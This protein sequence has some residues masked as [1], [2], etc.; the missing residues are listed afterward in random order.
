MNGRDQPPQRSDPL[1]RLIRQ[2]GFFRNLDRFDLA[3]LIGALEKV[4]FPS[5][6]FVFSE[7][8]DADALYLLESGRVSVTVTAANDDRILTEL[9]APSHFG[10]LGLLL[11]RRTGS[12]RAVTD[13]QVWKLPRQ[14][15]EEFVRE[16]P[17]MG[18]AVAA[19]LAELIDQRSREHAGAPAPSHASPLPV[20][21]PSRRRPPT[22]RLVGAAI[23][24]AVPLALWPIGPPRG[25]GTQ[26]WH[27]ALIICG[28]ALAWLSEPVPDFVVAL[29]MPTAWGIA[30]LVPLSVA[31]GGF[32]SSAWLVALGALGLGAAMAR[33]GLLFRIALRLMR[34]FPATYVGQL[35]A[36]LS[37][38]VLVT[39]L[40]PLA[41]ARVAT[42]APLAQELSQALGCPDRSRGSA[43]LSFAGIIGYGAFSSIF[44]TGLAMNFFVLDLVPPYDRAR[45]GWLS[46]LVGA[47]LAGV[48]ILIGATLA[49]LVLFRPETVPKS[50]PDLIRRQQR[51]LG[52]LSHAEIATITAITILIVGLILQPFFRT[53]PA[54]LAIASLIVILGG[55]ALDRGSFRASIDWGFLVLFGV[56]LGAGGVLHSVGVDRWLADALLPPIRSVGNPG[57]ILV[58]LGACV[59]ACRLVLPWIPATLLLSL[60]LVPAAPQL[61]LSPWL[62][63]FVILVT[64]NTWLH[65]NQSDFCRL[66]REATRGLMFT[67]RHGTLMGIAVTAVTLVAIA[68][69]LPYW[70]MI[71]LLA[72]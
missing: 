67:A 33:S 39:P 63:G 64:A 49:L 42:V 1:E 14:R 32:A 69:S 47:A 7:G 25:L 13:V 38:G 35:L 11:S 30:G 51:I 12:A 72:R 71:G 9:E 53:D 4:T 15:F 40:V 65:P 52:Q 46:W 10:E 57:T 2:V 20:L 36:L 31:F 17:G 56:L 28:A 5:G 37:G 16:R 70:R 21:V 18:L 59:V 6:T 62:V 22:A 27:V 19:A 23:A 26:A 3:R 45:F 61:G 60:A 24:L 55:G 54:W 34:T 29:A 50:A 41:L 58:V 68:L 48:I 66:T 8:A 44:L 43:G